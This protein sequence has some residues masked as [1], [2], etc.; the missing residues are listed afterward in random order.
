MKG[1]EDDDPWQASFTLGLVRRQQLHRDGGS[2][3]MG[4]MD[5]C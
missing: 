4:E 2:Q 3:A 5:G 1:S